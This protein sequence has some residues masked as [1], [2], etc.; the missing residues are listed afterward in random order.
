MSIASTR[1]TIC[2][3]LSGEFDSLIQPINAAQRDIKNQITDVKTTLNNLSF[4]PESVVDNKID[5]VENQVKEVVPEGN[6]ED[7]QETVDF[8][9]DCNFL[10]ENEL[11]RNPIALYN[12]AVNSTL[13]KVGQF[14]SDAASALPEF[15]A[16]QLIGAITDKFSGITGLS[17]PDALNISD[18]V[19]SADKLIN[20][21]AGRCGVD[22]ASRVTEMIDRLEG[23][24]N[25]LNIVSDPLDT[26]WGE[27]DTQALYDLAGFDP[28]QINQ[29][30]KVVTSVNQT[31]TTALS[32]INNINSSLKTASKSVQG[33]F[34]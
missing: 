17:I 13:D 12:G 4:S 29:M 19:R 3:R 32:S 22:Y 34:G 33:I 5:E 9:N 23:I 11:L 7:I 18:I 30:D 1:A 27:F 14:V 2:D 10:S 8:I 20:C 24:Y 6:P 25:D 28:S 26:N 21:M 31:K 16:A 15:N